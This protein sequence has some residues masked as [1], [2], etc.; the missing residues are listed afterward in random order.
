MWHR[1]PP[2]FARVPLPEA[3]SDHGRG[4]GRHYP[5]TKGFDS[6]AEAVPLCLRGGPPREV[7]GLAHP[8]CFVPSYGRPGFGTH[9][10]GKPVE[11]LAA[12]TPISPAPAAGVGVSL[13]AILSCAS[14][15]DRSAAH[16]Q[17]RKNR[18]TLCCRKLTLAS[19]SRLASKPSRD[20]RSGCPVAVG[21]LPQSGRA[22]RPGKASRPANKVAYL[23]F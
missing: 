13:G 4:F 5:V 16:G 9:F 3:R 15:Y 8:T 6:K 20:G 7:R 14:S 10:P 17:P 1:G 11:T 2:P 19:G 21:H 23:G 12:R 18:F 22:L